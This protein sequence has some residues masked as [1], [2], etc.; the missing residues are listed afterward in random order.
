MPQ[1]PSSFPIHLLLLLI[2]RHKH[3]LRAKN[4]FQI[5]EGQRTVQAE[6]EYA[7]YQ[8]G[9]IALQNFGFP[10]K[11]GWAS[12]ARTDKAIHACAQ[13]CNIKIRYTGPLAEIREKIN[14]HL[15]SDIVILDVV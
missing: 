3:H 4:G 8:S 5:N 15:P 9:L 7:L 13:L 11:Y 6:V 12:S 14:Q 2:T 10:I 1:L